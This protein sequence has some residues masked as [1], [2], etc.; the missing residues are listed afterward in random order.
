MESNK[1]REENINKKYN[2][3]LVLLIILFIL[4]LVVTWY[5]PGKLSVFDII[6]LSLRA[7]KTTVSNQNDTI[8][9]SQQNSI[10]YM[11]VVII[12][13][14]IVLFQKSYKN[15]KTTK[16]NTKKL[17]QKV[18]KFKR[19]GTN[20]LLLKNCVNLLDQVGFEHKYLQAIYG[21][22]NENSGNRSGGEIQCTLGMFKKNL[23]I[24]Q[25]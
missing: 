21:D 11:A 2:I 23:P 7:H 13:F 10:F 12:I 25:Y 4:A 17:A 14:Y 16:D 24:S 3:Y 9:I 18:A 6:I 15:I 19:N 20:E 22:N 1:Q 5:L 8:E